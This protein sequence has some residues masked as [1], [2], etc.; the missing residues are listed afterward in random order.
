LIQVDL[1]KQVFRLRTYIGLGLMVA[2]PIIIT[3]AL[4]LGG[5]PRDRNESNFFTVA[6]HS[7]LNVPLA[8][9]IV[10]SNFLLVVVVALF[11]GGAV[12]EEA[13]WGSLRYLLV[14]PVSRSRLLT[15]KLIV[16][17]VLAF[18]AT[19]L[20]SLS[21][22]IAGII[23]FGW[24]PVISPSLAVFSQGDAL[25]RLALATVFVAWSM[26]CVIAFAFMLSTMMDAP[27][28]AVA[29][30]VG[31]SIMSE[32]LNAIPALKSIRNWLPTHYW[33]AWEGLFARPSTTSDM[34]NGVLL[35]IPYVVF[36]L[37]LAWWWF[38][39]R[40]ILS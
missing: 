15:A 39:R 2:V 28:G 24:H 7:G 23:A 10:M 35:Q 38:Q 30:G 19:A 3:L 13:G 22:L 29:G 14:R 20:I 32:I 40:D 1:T 12:A 18:V 25:S 33:H 21:G 11:A 9:L 4:E 17:A 37:V 31:L 26:S 8:S 36:F 27:L 5:G 16:V 6:T 34:V